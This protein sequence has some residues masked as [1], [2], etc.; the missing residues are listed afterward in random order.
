MG[1]DQK[2]GPVNEE[3]VVLE[4]ETKMQDIAI[5]SLTEQ[6]NHWHEQVEQLRYQKRVREQAIAARIAQA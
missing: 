3:L 4:K 5:E 6:A 2:P 1:M